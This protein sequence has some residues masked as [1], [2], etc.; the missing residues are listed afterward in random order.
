MH[1]FK[2]LAIVV[3]SSALL[4]S[5]AALGGLSPA[6][7]GTPV[8]SP[9]TAGQRI[10]HWSIEAI[11]PGSYRVTWTSP[12]ALPTTDARPTVTFQGQTVTAT[13]ATRHSASA[14]LR[15]STAPSIA[16]L[17]V[18]LSGRTLDQAQSPTTSGPTAPATVPSTLAKL[19][20]D[21]GVPGDHKIV[22]SNYTLKPVQVVGMPEKVEMVGHVVRPADADPSDPLV[23]FLHGRHSACYSAAPGTK[24]AFTIP[25][26]PSSKLPVW[27]CPSG[28]QPIPSYLGYDYAQQLMASQGYVTVSISADAINDLDYQDSDGG[29]AARAELIEKHLAQWVKWVKAGKYEADMN[30]IVLIGHSRGGEGVAR[31]ST[32]IPLSAPYRVSGQVLIAPTDFSDQSPSYVPTVTML[33]Y[34]DGDVSDLQGQMFTDGSRDLTSDDTALHSSVLIMGADHNFFNSQWTPGLS[35]APSSDDWSGSPTAECGSQ[36]P[37]R[38][39]A[40]QQE[41]VAKTYLAGAV[42]LFAS[43]QDDLL[44]MFDGTA[45][46][47]KSAGRKADVRTETVGVGR[48]LR[49]PGIDAELASATGGAKTQICTAITG[50]D[51]SDCGYGASYGQTPHWL[52]NIEPE[53]EFEMQW[54]KSGAEGGLTFDTPLDLSSDTS[55]DL[56]TAVDPTIGDVTLDAVLH[57]SS[58]S[59]Q[60]TPLNG[61]LVPAL[62]VGASPLSKRWAQTLRIPLAGVTGI[63]LSAV[64]EVD[65]VAQNK[66]GNIFVLD[67][68]GVP[69]GMPAPLVKRLAVVNLPTTT[70]K[71]AKGAKQVQ[72]PFTIE[73]KLTTKA[74][75]IVFPSGGGVSGGAITEQLKPGTSKGTFTVSFPSGVPSSTSI[76]VD[77]YSTVGVTTGTYI[78][79][80]TISVQ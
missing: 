39:S 51:T 60:V 10:G 44:P 21:P 79:H 67:A 46:H 32:I 20:H 37:T 8:R 55:L 53:H 16:Q 38:L 19:K 43:G 9:V 15:L 12:T 3:S 70:V 34:C 25:A 45:L 4:C 80:D 57:D 5:A 71:V 75:F 69:K 22:T 65:L 30:N 48:V 63:D 62:P 29:A 26:E 72:I 54:T 73:N 50:G 24:P 76:E 7:A 61:G 47:V 77:A 14:I 64:T 40:L 35:Q 74:H 66:A 23:L 52:Q 78:A 28:Q 27:S 11:A 2:K 18:M 42:Q 36:F 59:V 56:R 17:H 33:G 68:A 58:G 31:A 1:A 6:N 49:R 41:R 13:T